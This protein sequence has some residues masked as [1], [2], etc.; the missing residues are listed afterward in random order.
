MY[1]YFENSVIATEICDC[2]YGKSF[3]DVTSGVNELLVQVLHQ[4]WMLYDNFWNIASSPQV[5]TPVKLEQI[6]LCADHGFTGLQA[7][8]QS[9]YKKNHKHPLVVRIT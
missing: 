2:A 6:S 3:D 1:I 9:W 4:M 8:D 5:A 7:I